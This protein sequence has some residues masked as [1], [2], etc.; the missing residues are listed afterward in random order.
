GRLPAVVREG[1]V[2]L[3]HPEDVVLALPGA[4][5][6][7]GR[8]EDLAGEAVRHRLLAAG[9]GELNEPAHRQGPRATGGHLDRDLV[10][11]AADAARAHLEVWRQLLD[12]LLQDLDRLAASALADDRE[13][14]VDDSLGKGLLAGAHD[15]V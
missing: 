10:G 6:L 11:G 9:A 15:L 13:R 2:R 8:V 3:G 4:A 7:L 5:L 14:V 12:R 1:L